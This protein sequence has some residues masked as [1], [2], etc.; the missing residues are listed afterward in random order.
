MGHDTHRLR[1]HHPA[2][3]LLTR[4]RAAAPKRQRMKIENAVPHIGALVTGLN[5]KRMTN[6]EWQALYQTW[7]DRHVLIVR[8][9]ELSKADFLAL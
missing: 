3:L 2:E 6:S 9:Q 7:L 5:V 1:Q 4:S 8:G